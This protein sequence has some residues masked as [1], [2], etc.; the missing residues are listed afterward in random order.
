[1][2]QIDF[3]KVVDGDDSS[4]LLGKRAEVRVRSS[5]ISR[6]GFE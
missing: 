3:V 6:G 2:P 5:R 1:M 4:P